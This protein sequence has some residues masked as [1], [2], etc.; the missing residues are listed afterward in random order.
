MAVK[1]EDADE[2]SLRSSSRLSASST[3]KYPGTG[4][5]YR[6]KGVICRKRTS[7]AT[8]S[9]TE[10]VVV[11]MKEKAADILVLALDRLRANG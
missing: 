6:V 7:S 4:K 3:L 10:A 5:L 11:G 8:W 2:K 1:R 9:S